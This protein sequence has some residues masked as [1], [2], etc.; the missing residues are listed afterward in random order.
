[1][2]DIPVSWDY[3]KFIDGYPGK[4]VIMAR[5][6]GNTWYV[7][8]I[9]GEKTDKKLSIDLSFITASKGELISDVTNREVKL[10]EINLKK[11]G[12]MD[13]SFMPNGGFVMKFIEQ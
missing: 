2:K 1:M 6:T 9:N 11:D 4:M 12:K 10:E 8:G 3:S 5:K 13:V 7:A